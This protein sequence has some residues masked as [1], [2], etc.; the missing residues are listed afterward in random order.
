MKN[1]ILVTKRSGGTEFFSP[2]KIHKVLEWACEG[3]SG[4]SV[5]EIEIRANLQIFEGIATSNIHDLLIKSAAELI[6]ED[7]PN[8]QYVAAKLVNYKLRKEVYGD[9]EPKMLYH[10]VQE[11][12]NAGVYDP[13][14][15]VQYSEEEFDELQSYIKHDR[16][17]NFT[18]AGMEQFRGKYLAQDR[19]VKRIYETPQVL[20]ML[21]A[22]T[23]FSS[24]PKQTRL[25]YV[26][27]LYDAAS[28]FYISLPTPI[29]AGCRTPTRQYSSCV[30]V[31]SGDSLDSINATA[32]TV[33]RYASKKAGLG[34]G[35]GRIRAL[36]SKVGDGSVVHTG[37]VPFLKYLFG[38]LRSCSQGGVRGAS[39]TI[40]VPFFHREI[41]DLMVLKNSKGTEET[42]IRHLD[43]CVQLNKLVYERMTKGEYLT[44]FSPHD[45]PDM[46]DAFFEDQDK[47]KQ[48]YE[49]YEQDETLVTKKILASDFWEILLRER[50]ETSR[51]YIM[52]V[53]HANEHG[54]FIP[55]VAPIR[56]T[57]LCV[58]ITLPTDWFETLNKIQYD[59]LDNP[60]KENGEVALCTLAAINWGLINR[61]E[62]FEKYCIILVRALDAILDYQDYM[63]MHAK[64][65]THGRR[66][67]GV[68]IIN[69]AYFLAKRNLKYNRAAL[70][71]VHEY[72]EAWSFYMI[73]ASIELAKERG[74]GAERIKDTK[75]SLGILPI[76]TYKKSLDKIVKPTYYMD[77]DSLRPDL[78][79]GFMMNSTLM[80]GM[81]AETSAQ[82]LNATSG[83]DQVLALVTKKKSKDG[84]MA[85]V[86]PEPY[87]LKN[88]Y[89]LRFST[90]G[91]RGYLEVMSVLQK[92]M[93]QSIST[94]TSYDLDAFPNREV[95][96][97]TLFEDIAYAYSL[98]IKTLYYSNTKGE[99]V[100]E[101]AE[102]ELRSETIEED[103][104]EACKL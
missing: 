102:V 69:L 15:L 7:T 96:M 52:N 44:L 75:Y 64:S 36:G 95:P 98:G 90:P 53:D 104:C 48:L 16:D 45:V 39:A 100:E 85:Q 25:K 46:Y 18:Y 88:K 94:N 77:W 27:D 26:K 74:H 24:Y 34:I 5:S 38:A 68:G 29:M 2:D 89:D 30:L 28:Q 65:A 20:Y 50:Q 14:L 80:A 71:T 86:V 37:V 97:S 91:P 33:V 31:E 1:N 84:I 73:K 54:S 56:M 6:N 92:F 63:V 59:V 82:P 76:D 66:P 22:A 58:E 72:A 4:V 43:Y 70:E 51:I 81:P 32:S 60:I 9:Y 67:L 79:D 19:S 93:D 21:V 55:K 49:K 17:Y 83:V 23:I 99:K 103:D 12:I 3:Q 42:R 40:N 47:F 78:R 57:N 87:R 101:A 41:E 62:E 35:V 61:P 10:I 8:Y 13:E 11:N